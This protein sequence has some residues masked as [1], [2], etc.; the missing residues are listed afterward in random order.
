MPVDEIQD[1]HKAA[2]FDFDGVVFQPDAGWKIIDARLGVV[3]SRVRWERG[4][5]LYENYRRHNPDA[6]ITEC[7]A[8][9]EYAYGSAP[10]DGAL[11]ITPPDSVMKTA[12]NHRFRGHDLILLSQS[13]HRDLL[14]IT[15]HL[16]GERRFPVLKNPFEE[17][18]FLSPVEQ[19]P[20][21]LTGHGIEHKFAIISELLAYKHNLRFN[22]E[23]EPDDR[24]RYHKIYLYTTE[25]AYAQVLEDF[26]RKNLDDLLGGRNAIVHSFIAHP[27]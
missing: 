15:E 11:N 23:N 26:T 5:V 19:N 6:L 16:M 4:C 13:S 22:T 7:F 14:D 9:D 20:L 1:E 10:V 2:I 8:L 17:A 24:G 18:R 12:Q 25:P 21:I 3:G 27:A